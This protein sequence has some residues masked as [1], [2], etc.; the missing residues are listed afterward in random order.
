MNY[1]ATIDPTL[2]KQVESQRVATLTEIP[3][4]LKGKEPDDIKY[5][6]YMKARHWLDSL[7][8][9]EYTPINIP[10]MNTTSMPQA[11]ALPA[12]QSP[13]TSLRPTPRRRRSML[14]PSAVP[15]QV[16]QIASTLP[17]S[18]KNTGLELMQFINKIPDFKI[19]K[20]GSISY[21]GEHFP[22]TDYHELIHDFTRHRPT[23]SPPRGYRILA[24]ALR[25]ANAPPRLV[26][27]PSRRQYITTGSSGQV[28]DGDEFMDA[29]AYQQVGMGLT[30]R[31]AP[32][33]YMKKTKGIK[34][35]Q[36]V[37][38]WKTAKHG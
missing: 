26:A 32:T 5:Q 12:P 17:K 3:K 33:W 29:P 21:K 14:S 4:I 38:R 22:D 34:K 25:D 27:N 30:T 28:D 9:Q 6:F 16:F 15:S 36:H 8:D 35:L 37:K 7:M 23:K 1:V 18:L 24:S 2:F 10:V 19:H 13:S 20:D 11:P 31:K